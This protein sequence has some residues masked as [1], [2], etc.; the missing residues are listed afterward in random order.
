MLPERRE[1][2][3]SNYNKLRLSGWIGVIVGVILL[4]GFIH[5]Y[6]VGSFSLQNWH[7]D[8]FIMKG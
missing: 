5:R 3:M 8:Y 7:S 2:V 1:I 6:F 4:R